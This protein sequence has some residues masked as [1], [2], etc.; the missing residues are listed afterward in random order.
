M[1]GV[2]SFLIKKTKKRVGMER[3]FLYVKLNVKNTV[4]APILNDCCFLLF[5]L[6]EHFVYMPTEVDIFVDQTISKAL[7]NDEDE[8]SSDVK[9]LF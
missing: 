7:F 2:L 5:V 4:T 1:G 6:A 9:W 3:S 8:T